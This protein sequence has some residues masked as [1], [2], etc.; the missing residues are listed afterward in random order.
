M[1][2]PAWRRARTAF[3]LLAVINVLVRL[4]LWMFYQPRV[5]GDSFTYLAPARLLQQGNYHLHDGA[6]PPGYPLFLLATG[7]DP[8]RTWALQSVLGIGVSLL[9]FAIG[10]RLSGSVALGFTAGLAH[11]LSP[12]ALFLEPFLI[13]ETL[14]TFLLVLGCALL[15]VVEARRGGAAMLSTGAGM[16]VAALALT[17]PAYVYLVPLGTIFLAVVWRAGR[18]S[19][20]GFLLP[21]VVLVG[22]LSLYN[23]RH[24]GVFTP[25]TMT[26]FNL[27]QHTGAFVELAPQRDA[28]LRDIYL[29][30][31]ARV[32]ARHRS[33]VGTIWYALPEM[34]RRTGLNDARLSQRWTRLSLELIA[35]HPA[36]YL[37]SVA[38]AWMA[39]WKRPHF[40]RLELL[41]AP[42]LARALAA[43]W[44][45]VRPVAIAV[46]AAFLAVA[47]A[48]LWSLVR[49]RQPPPT[50][51]FL[52]MVVLAGSLVQAM[53]E[54]GGGRFAVPSMPLIQLVVL[55]AL[56][57]RRRPV[58]A[59][60]ETREAGAGS[61]AAG[62]ARPHSR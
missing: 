2:L 16:V 27:S 28:L 7:L 33:H 37:G 24:L 9:V 39:Y 3:V 43:A 35:R 15:V 40:W 61:E 58:P 4:P 31:R 41:R 62:S 44:R 13:S 60:A 14:A 38:P 57:P 6:R 21:A 59:S 23:L 25:Y 18:R 50:R 22:G 30:H 34:R 8:H 5:E 17:R 47:A 32:V 49:G 45:W 36:R 55:E 56:W 46:N 48:T 10:L 20:M 12:D 11:A 53:S 52:V 1:S 26:G 19:A 54:T 42:A 51:V 29:A